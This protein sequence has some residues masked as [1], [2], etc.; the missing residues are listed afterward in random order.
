MVMP[1]QPEPLYRGSDGGPGSYETE[2]LQG[3]VPFIEANY[4][5]D[6]SARAIAGIS[7]GGVWALEI[8]LRNPLQF[9]ALA[10]LSPALAVNSARLPYDPFEIA[11]T[12]DQFPREILLLAGDDDW[13]EAETQ[14]LSE[15]LSQAGVEHMLQISAGDHSDGTWAEVME[16]VLGFLALSFSP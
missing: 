14:R 13:A 12:A 5:S 9:N 16:D 11:S 2:L 15:V 4:R 8:A 6:P 3:L 7:R 1:Q 10:A